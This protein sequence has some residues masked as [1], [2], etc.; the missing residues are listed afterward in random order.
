MD[1]EYPYNLD[2]DDALARLHALSDYLE[3][4]HGIKCLWDGNRGSIS[5]KYL[6][7][8]IVAEMTLAERKILFTGKD[9]GILWR[10]KATGYMQKKL[11]QY[12]DPDTPLDELPRA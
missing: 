12:L 6:V 8:K 4:R 11:G 10:K 5:G 2:I 3:N 9:P 1:F 7:V